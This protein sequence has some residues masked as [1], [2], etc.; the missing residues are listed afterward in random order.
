M[1]N[2]IEKKQEDEERRKLGVNVDKKYSKSFIAVALITETIACIPIIEPTD[3]TIFQW[4][5]LSSSAEP[6]R[7]AVILSELSK[8]GVRCE[9]LSDG[10]KVYPGNLHG[11]NQ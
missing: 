6:I 7:I 8:L 9:E 4:L 1:D 2:V 3:N 5:N 10:I 11:G